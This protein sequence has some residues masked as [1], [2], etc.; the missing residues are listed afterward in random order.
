MDESHV[1]DGPTRPV[2]ADTNGGSADV[3]D[4]AK[5]DTMT[6]SATRAAAK[7][8]VYIRSPSMIAP[9]VEQSEPDSS[10]FKP[11]TRQSYEAQL[12]RQAEKDAAE[13]QRRDAPLEERLVDGRLTFGEGN[14]E[15]DVVAPRD[16]LAEGCKLPLSL[17][18]LP[19]ALVGVPLEEID[20]GITSKVGHWLI[21]TRPNCCPS[22]NRLI[23]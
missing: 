18:Y 16:D 23:N 2:S 7:P 11:F 5:D 15:E 21:G 20:P 8:S 9:S 1:I 3:T 4:S 19:P 17:G 12:T 6:S 22:I 10:R 14:Q 13:Q